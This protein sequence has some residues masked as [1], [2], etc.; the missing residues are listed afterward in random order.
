MIAICKRCLSDIN[1]ITQDYCVHCGRKL[2]DKKIWHN[3]KD[4][5]RVEYIGKYVKSP[6][7]YGIFS[8][9]IFIVKLRFENTFQ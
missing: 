9:A 4:W 5:L 2:K 6:H 8:Y 7:R 3:I 1:L